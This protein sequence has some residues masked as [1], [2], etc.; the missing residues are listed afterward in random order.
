M[1]KRTFSTL[2]TFSLML[3][4]A[5]VS[6]AQ[7]A[8]TSG[9]I[10]LLK[11]DGTREPVAG[12][13]IEVY[14]TDIKRGS[15]SAKTDRRGN[16]NFVGLTLGGTFA[17]SVSAPGC[18]PIVYPGVRA[19]QEKIL[20][21]MR[22]GDG[23]KLTEEEARRLAAAGTA[24]L[25]GETRQPT[26]DE[27]KAAAEFA[28]QTKEIEERNKKAEKTNEIIARTLREGN[29]AVESK[30]YDVAVEK[31]N[32]GI[33][34][35]PNF[36][37][38][39]PVLM[40]N[41]GIALKQRAIINYNKS[42]PRDLPAEEKA[43][44]V[45]QARKDLLDSAQSFLGAWNLLANAN[46]SD[47]TDRNNYQENKKN[48]AFLAR[49]TFRDAVR[50]KLVSPQLTE[51]ATVMIAEYLKLETDNNQKAAARLILADMYRLAQE[52]ENAVKAYKEILE[53][54]PD[55][56]DAMAGA[57]LMLVDLGWV[58]DNKDATQEGANYLARFVAAAADSHELKDG[59]KQYLEILKT[60]NVTPVRTPT[61]P[62]RRN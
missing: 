24:P 4:F 20:I 60:Q 18:A 33:A 58:N 10:E 21:T 40:N 62:R 7:V 15:P 23:S 41:R 28:A 46:P 52:R 44:F 36:V 54:S 61:P 29:A 17:F 38:A 48:A 25:P 26:E 43:A 2:I 37:G 56:V 34:A 59:A 32:E 11:E 8:Q 12:A 1:L 16:F 42:V 39:A 3:A 53:T 9:T 35:D 22:P 19:G 31:Y 47:I 14:Q 13:L 6:N 5:L 50:T 45:G 57:G 27:K 49:D 51:V 30:N 55:N